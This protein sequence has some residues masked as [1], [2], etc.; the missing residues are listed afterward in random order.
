MHL[1]GSSNPLRSWGRFK[2]CCKLVCDLTLGHRLHRS[3]GV[4]IQSCG[5]LVLWSCGHLVL[6]SSGHLVIWSSAH[7]L[8]W[9][10]AHVVMCSRAKTEERREKTDIIVIAAYLSLAGT[11]WMP[12]APDAV[13]E[14]DH[15][16]AGQDCEGSAPFR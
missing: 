9:S 13:S 12:V 1:Q 15:A 6:W 8:M 16:A 14:C 10:C 11:I 7:V 2:F 4:V 5:H 3:N